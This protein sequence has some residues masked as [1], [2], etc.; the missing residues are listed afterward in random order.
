MPYDALPTSE[1][2]KQQT[3]VI[4]IEMLCSANYHYAFRCAHSLERVT[5]TSALER[6]T[7]I[8]SPWYYQIQMMKNHYLMSELFR[9]DTANA[10]LIANSR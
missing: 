5:T 7:A 4:M 3:Q 10:N 6:V 8:T 1:P 2:M 9:K